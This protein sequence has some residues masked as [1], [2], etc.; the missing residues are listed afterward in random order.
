MCKLENKPV[1]EE[2]IA[3][4]VSAQQSLSLLSVPLSLPLS[5]SP[6]GTLNQHPTPWRHTCVDLVG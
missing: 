4:E 5:L 6:L 3:D 1:S 2:R